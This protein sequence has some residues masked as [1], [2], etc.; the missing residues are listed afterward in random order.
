MNPD[1]FIF[2]ESFSALDSLTAVRVIKNIMV[3]CCG[4]TMIFI[5]HNFAGIGETCDMIYVF[6]NGKIIE[7]GKHR[8]LIE[9]DTFYRKLTMA[10]SIGRSQII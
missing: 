4:K 9:R 6:N 3:K 10:R 7:S 8:D 2:D 1:T 5:S